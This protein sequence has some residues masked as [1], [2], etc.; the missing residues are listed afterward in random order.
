MLKDSHIDTQGCEY[1]GFG[2]EVAKFCVFPHSDVGM[3][4]YFGIL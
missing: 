4:N 3:G 2:N 1:V